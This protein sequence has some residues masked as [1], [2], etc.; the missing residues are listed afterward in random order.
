MLPTTNI[1]P[2]ST[3]PQYREILDHVDIAKNGGA[4]CILGG[5]PAEGFLGG[6]FVEP[7]I[8]TDVT[9]QTRIAREEVF[10]PVL[11]VPCP[12]LHSAVRRHEAFRHR[13]R[14]RHRG[15]A[16]IPRDLERL[17]LHRQGR[18]G[19]SLRDALERR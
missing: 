17:D 9:P 10:G 18:A 19:Q 13:P 1:G 11:P 2:V 12:Q 15:G 3:A 5:G 4:R 14:E 16:G 6:Q 7:T 8:F